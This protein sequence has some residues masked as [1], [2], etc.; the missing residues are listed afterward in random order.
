M[1]S[2]VHV[3][4]YLLCR[5]IFSLQK[6]RNVMRKIYYALFE[7]ELC[8]T[9]KNWVKYNSALE[10]WTNIPHRTREKE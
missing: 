5:F 2:D 6:I 7:N 8:V 3:A 10:S 4:D 9:Q 1:D